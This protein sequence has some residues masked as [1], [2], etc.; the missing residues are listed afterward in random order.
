MNLPGQ[1]QPVEH[2]AQTSSCSWSAAA[3]PIRIG[4]DRSYRGTCGTAAPYMTKRALAQRYGIS[5]RSVKRR[6]TESLTFLSTA[7][8]K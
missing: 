3:L 7:S 4:V 5:V 2:R 6:A 8:E 1:V